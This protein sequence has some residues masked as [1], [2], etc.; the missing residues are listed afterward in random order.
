MVTLST[1]NFQSIVDATI[2]VDGFTL[3][4]GETSAGKSAFLRAL[5]ASTGNKY[6]SGYV[7]YGEKELETSFVADGRTFSTRKSEGGGTTMMLDDVTFTKMGRDVPSDI[8]DYLNFGV[9]EVNDSKFN[10]NIHPQFQKPLLLEF[11]QKKVME[12]LSTSKG[13]SDLKT[14]QSLLT[15]RRAEVKG[16][17]TATDNIRADTA[18]NLEESKSRMEKIEPLFKTFQQTYENY[19]QLSTRCERLNALNELIETST[20]L[21]EKV[22]KQSSAIERLGQLIE[23]QNVENTRLSSLSSL[24]EQ[25]DDIEYHQRRESK[26]ERKISI[27]TKI[28]GYEDGDSEY[29]K[30]YDTLVKL[31]DLWLKNLLVTKKIAL[32]EERVKRAS[33]V[34][35]K[36]NELDALRQRSDKLSALSVNVQMLGET[37]KRIKELDMICNQN[38][39]PICGNKLTEKHYD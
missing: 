39:C 32:Y 24:K 1:R 6:R 19:R 25:S 15:A 35:D 34:A 30:K 26:L 13:I 18:R 14:A 5:T 8:K 28:V 27:L 31:N 23:T 29:L 38:I 37:R 11:S 33:A 2:D 36:Q 20:R 12:I 22:S 16:A 4:V 3:L 10:L 7:R 17:I 9:I 21:R